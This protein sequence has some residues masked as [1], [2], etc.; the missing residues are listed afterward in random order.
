MHLLNNFESFMCNCKCITVNLTFYVIMLLF[1]R[2]LTKIS[3]IKYRSM[4]TIQLLAT[5]HIYTHTLI[6]VSPY[7]PSTPRL[8]PP[9]LPTLISALLLL[10]CACTIA[11]F[12]SAANS[13]SSRGNGSVPRQPH[14]VP[15]RH[16]WRRGNRHINATSIW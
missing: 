11:R 4:H 7:S 5:K 9:S 3:K 16:S 15:R 1:I 13:R 2:S 10:L 6:S 12:H 8:S 14:A